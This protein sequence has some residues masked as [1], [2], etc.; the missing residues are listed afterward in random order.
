MVYLTVEA[1]P[2]EFAAGHEDFYRAASRLRAGKS[3]GDDIRCWFAT[4]ARSR[5]DAV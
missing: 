4:C 1:E 3:T 5:R 2:F